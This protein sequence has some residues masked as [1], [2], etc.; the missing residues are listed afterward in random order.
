VLKE[1]R[2]GKAKEI[3]SIATWYK[4]CFFPLFCYYLEHVSDE[5]KH[6][7]FHVNCVICSGVAQWW[8]EGRVGTRSARPF[9]VF[10]EK[11]K[12]CTAS[13]RGC[14]KSAL[15]AGKVIHDIARGHGMK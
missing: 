10:S 1:A 7:I 11:S 14:A 5:L 6:C 12:R 13:V 8:S 2:R 15:L 9:E 4:L 3:E